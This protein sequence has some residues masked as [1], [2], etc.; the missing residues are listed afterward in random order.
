MFSRHAARRIAA[1]LTAALVAVLLVTFGGPARASAH[2]TT[3][4]NPSHAGSAAK[5]ARTPQALLAAHHHQQTPQHLD[6]AS[7][8]PTATP[9][10]RPTAADA[11]PETLV[12]RTGSDRVTPTGRAPPA[13]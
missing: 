5:A 12:V 11:T 10:V 9:D 13:L 3:V 7:T 4:G 8:P 1:A 2:R 6:L